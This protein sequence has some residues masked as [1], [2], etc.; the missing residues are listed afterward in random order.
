MTLHLIAMGL[1]LSYG[2]TQCYLTPDTSELTPPSPQP[3]RLVVDLPAPEGWKAEL[4]THTHIHT[5]LQTIFT[6]TCWFRLSSEF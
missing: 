6:T 3:H 1:H 2:I 5:Y 4:T